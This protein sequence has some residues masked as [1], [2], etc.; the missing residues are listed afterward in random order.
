[1]NLFSK[2]IKTGKYI[3]ST[4]TV[5]ELYFGRKCEGKKLLCISIYQRK[6]VA[7][8][9]FADKLFD[10]MFRNIPLNCI[11]IN[12]VRVQNNGQEVFALVDGRQR[13]SAIIK[14]IERPFSFSVIE[15]INDEF[16]TNGIETQEKSIIKSIT[17]DFKRIQ[18][19]IKKL[20]MIN[21][22]EHKSL[23]QK[24]LAQIKS[25]SSKTKIFW[26]K[27]L[28]LYLE[29]INEVY[30]Q[31]LESTIHIYEIE[32]ND[33]YILE[34]FS[35]TSTSGIPMQHVDFI[36]ATWCKLPFITS[37]NTTIKN[38]MENYT[39][40]IVKNEQDKDDTKTV[41]ENIIQKKNY[42]TYVYLQSLDGYLA[43]KFSVYRSYRKLGDYSHN[44]LLI[45]NII[46]SVFNFKN[47]SDL[48]SFLYK[49]YKKD[50]MKDFEKKIYNLTKLISNR[51]GDFI[52][53]TSVS[54]KN[55]LDSN[56]LYK[57]Y[58]KITDTEIEKKF[59][60]ELDNNFINSILLTFVF[61]KIGKIKGRL[62]FDISITKQEINEV[63]KAYVIESKNACKREPSMKDKAI[64]YLAYVPYKND[65]I[66][67]DDY[68]ID[69]VLSKD[70]LDKKKLSKRI[71]PTHLGNLIS[72][73]GKL[74]LEK[75]KYDLK[76]IIKDDTH[77]KTIK[78][79]SFAPLKN[80]TKL[81]DEIRNSKYTTKIKI[82]TYN[83]IMCDNCNAI[84]EQ[85]MN[86]Y[87]FMFNDKE[88]E[89]DEDS[90]EV[91]YELS[92]NESSEAEYDESPKEKYKSKKTKRRIADEL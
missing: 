91:E 6:D 61:K 35:R 39:K 47:I 34:V 38:N 63:F 30:F 66:I 62:N 76:S 37:S 79:A 67:N 28:D 52:N 26:A 42:S 45:S 46:M 50:T 77:S 10:S 36:G 51:L 2:P 72:L 53:Y 59:K 48:P 60:D 74:N 23:K 81:T 27:Y 3:L 82:K 5:K 22:V 40:K 1:M 31:I 65:D 32:G 41:I 86:D 73:P 75:G 89:N 49:Q 85:I 88:E 68:H 19:F 24:L 43:S 4:M 71:N 83:D 64:L 25:T 20:S 56:E 54:G 21:V 7:D 87:G 44:F 33:D 58:A 13:T 12:K 92:D 16:L 55:F 80:F 84:L 69:H 18:K 29:K 17:A 57:I 90:F 9:K 15:N 78:R 8:D 11:Y 14:I 70:F